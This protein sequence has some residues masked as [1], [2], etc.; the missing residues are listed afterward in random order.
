LISYSWLLCVVLGWN[1]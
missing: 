1:F